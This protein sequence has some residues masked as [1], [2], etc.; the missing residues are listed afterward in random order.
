MPYTNLK[1]LYG[2][3]FRVKILTTITIK[4]NYRDV[5]SGNYF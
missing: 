4:M 2:N 1:S 3:T 5:E